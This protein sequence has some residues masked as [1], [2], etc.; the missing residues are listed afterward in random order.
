MEDGIKRKREL[1]AQVLDKV[2]EVISD[3]NKAK[4]VDQV[5]SALHSLAILLFPI[6]ASLFIGLSHSHYS[7][8]RSYDFFNHTGIA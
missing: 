7:R 8:L 6:D 2:G 1:E 5:I 3:I 4:H